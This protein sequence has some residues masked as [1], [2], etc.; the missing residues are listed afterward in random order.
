MV[1]STYNLLYTYGS[2]LLFLGFL[3]AEARCHNV[4]AFSPIEERYTFF[5][6][7]SHVLSSYTRVSGMGHPSKTTS[8]L[9]S[10]I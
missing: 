2:N 4:V 1:E 9:R 8:G 10:S 3:F 5:S 7:Y 6:W